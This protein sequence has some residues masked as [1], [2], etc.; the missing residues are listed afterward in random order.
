MPPETYV[1]EVR[2]EAGSDLLLL[3]A[4]ICTARLAIIPE[5]VSPYIPHATSLAASASR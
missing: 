4:G 2:A 1:A 5:F 3:A